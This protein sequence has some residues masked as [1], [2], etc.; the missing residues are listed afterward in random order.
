MI[1]KER[2]NKLC[3]YN[4]SKREYDEIIDEINNRVSKIWR[5]ICKISKRRVK[6]HAFRNDVELDNGNGSTGG[7]FDPRADAVFIELGGDYDYDYDRDGDYAHGFYTRFLWTEDD[8]WQKEVIN[9]IESN[10]RKIEIKKQKKKQKELAE[11]EERDRVVAIIKSKLTK[12]EIKYVQ[13]K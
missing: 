1:A 3:D 8:V 13:F 4:I 2:V 12:E 9:H 7:S 5:E 10:K 6:W 11:K